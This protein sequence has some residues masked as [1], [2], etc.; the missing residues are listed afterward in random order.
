MILR[1]FI[2]TIIIISFQSA[3]AIPESK[4]QPRLHGAGD[5][6]QGYEKTLYTT[7]SKALT[8][9]IGQAASLIT[10][11]NKP[12]LGLPA[13]PVPATNPITKEKIALGRKMFFDR[14]LSLNNTFSCAMCHVPEQG[15]T[16]HELAVAVGIEG[17]SG[18]RNSPTLLNIAYADKLFHDGRED[19][20]EQQVWGPLL[21]H[22]EM[23]NPSPGV[24]LRK[25]RSLNDYD[26]LFE[27]AFNEP[28]SMD[29][30]GKALA[31][32][33]RSLNAANSPFDQ[34][35]F[36]GKKN[37][38]SQDAIH[39]FKLFT[40]KGNCVACHHIKKETALFTDNQLHNTGHG[41][42]VSMFKRPKTQPLLIAPGQYIEID[43]TLFD[44]VSE[45]KPNDVGLYEIT[46]NPAD[47][48]KYKT[49]S[50][51]NVALTAPYMHDGAFKSLRQ[52]VE[53]Y[54]QGGVQNE[55]LSPLIK[56]LHLTEQE[57][58]H[59]VEFLNHLTGSNVDTLISDAF[60]AGIEQ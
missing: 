28:V 38:M 52:V 26:G 16:S 57:V 13:V 46:E 30:V 22:N 19:T 53:F 4:T 24:V 29:T 20:L 2:I 5:V 31:S 9:R 59:L 54:N 55:N 42:S 48:W 50:L 39:G 3:F 14:R 8:Q 1:L 47:R 44:T 17:R 12:P 33:Q 25:L 18:R 32:Y 21:A 15:F 56:P 7:Q 58:S 51:R 49:P 41:Y 23:G 40:Q 45:R 34:W 6:K 37:T 10:L 27:K 43:S 11:V 35:Y 60:A 36:A